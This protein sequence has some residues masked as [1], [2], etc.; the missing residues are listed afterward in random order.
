MI[1]AILIGSIAVTTHVLAAFSYS[2]PLNQLY[3]MSCYS[4][5]FS[6]LTFCY[7][8]ETVWEGSHEWAL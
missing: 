8:G 5:L 4:F 2:V 7:V 3:P 1:I 6:G